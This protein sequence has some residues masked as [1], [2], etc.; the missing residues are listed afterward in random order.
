MTGI[1]DYIWSYYNEGFS[2]IPLKE[3]DK[4]P[5]IP[6]WKTYENTQPTEG[7]IKTWI[8]NGLFKNIGI[9]CGAISNNLVVIDIDDDKIISEIGL[10]INKIMDQGQWVVKTGRG[11]HI[12]CRNETNPG[13]TQ[14]DSDVHIEYRA[15]GGYVVAPPSIHPSGVEYHFFNREHPNQLFSLQYTDAKALYN[16]LVQKVKKKRGLTVDAEKPVVDLQKGVPQGNRNDTAFTK[17]NKYQRSG[18]TKAET[19][20]LLFKWNRKNKPPLPDSEIIQVIHS[21]YSYEKHIEE[22]RKLLKQYK[23]LSFKEKTNDETGEKYYI[24]IG[25]NCPRLAKLIMESDGRHYI[26]LKD[27]QDIYVDNGSYYE[28]IGQGIIEN[29]VSYYLD[30]LTCKKYKQEVVDFIRHYKYVER[31]DLNPP[32]NLINLKNGVL[33][34]ETKKLSPHTPDIYFLRELPIIYDPQAK[35]KK[36]DQFFNDLLNTEDKKIIQEFLGDCLQRTYKNKKSL[37]CVGITDTGKSQLLGLMGKFLGEENTSNVSLYQL[38]TDK[39]STIELYGRYA[40][41]AADIGATGL[42]F[43]ELFKMVTGG[44]RLRGQKKHKDSFEFKNYAKLVFSCNQIPDSTDKSDAYYNRWIVIEFSTQFDKDT[45]NPNILNDIT[46]EEEMSGLLNYALEGYYRLEENKGYSEHRSLE[47]VREFMQK[48]SN[49]IAE[50]VTTH[51]ELDSKSVITKEKLYSA[52]VGFCQLFN[53]PTKDSNV[54]SRKAKQYFPFGYDEGKSKKKR[55]WQ[56]I[57]CTFGENTENDINRN[58]QILLKGEQ[59]EEK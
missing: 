45:R 56:G 37:M 55:N 57:K 24:P 23:V 1:E 4:K 30:D 14:K 27:N 20:D 43:T 52:Y 59:Q 40:N 19:T 18:L 2:I 21:A 54:F 51:V 5:N 7:E 36:I 44:D 26:S 34:I 12:Y 9:I 48:G 32:L 13:G 41:I 6:T 17:A 35:I 16:D 38:C 29:R 33:D 53:Y 25:A 10:K 3:K 28:P 47:E 42:K 50:F 22:K 15:N 39:F 31:K 46:T 58:Q 49:P 11:W 8:D